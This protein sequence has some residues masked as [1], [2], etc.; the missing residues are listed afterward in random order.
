MRSS[1]SWPR[2]WLSVA[3]ASVVGAGL[4]TGA[5][6]AGAADPSDLAAA[7]P[8]PK[9]EWSD[10][11]GGFQCAT[12]TV[13]RDYRDRHGPV[14]RLPVI[15]WPAKDQTRR[16]GT[17]FVNPGGP[18][19]SGVGFLRGAPPGALDTFARF[20]VVGWDP[21]GI[22]G[23]VPALDCSTPEEDNA[24]PSTTFTP[25]FELD[26]KAAVRSARDSVRTG[27][28]CPRPAPPTRTRSAATTSCG[29][30]R[31]RCTPGTTGR[32]CRRRCGGPRPATPA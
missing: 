28:R 10:C 32:C 18:G 8:A 31:T 4:L 3:V 1:S 2:R 26:L 22:A 27:C 7:V 30:P 6:R 11:G 21:R 14:F 9:L 16:I 29:R 5:G 17:M 25:L 20:D 23:S 24:S 15:K 13:P 19:G 12:A